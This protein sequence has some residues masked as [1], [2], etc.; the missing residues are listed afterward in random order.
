MVSDLCQLKSGRRQKVWLSH[1]KDTLSAAYA[2][3]DKDSMFE[4]GITALKFKSS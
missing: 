3:Q 1:A 2:M 4:V